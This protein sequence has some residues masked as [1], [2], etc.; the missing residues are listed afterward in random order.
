MEQRI[1]AEAASRQN[2]GRLTRQGSQIKLMQD[3]ALIA[4]EAKDLRRAIKATLGRV[5]EFAEWDLGHAFLPDGEDLSV[6]LPSGIWVNRDPDQGRFA[7][8]MERTGQA[9]LRIGEDLFGPL[10]ANGEPVVVADV[11]RCDRFMRREMAISCDLHGAF[12]LAIKANGKAIAVLEFYSTR[13]GW[14]PEDLQADLFDIGVHLGRVAERTLILERLERAA[15]EAVAANQAKTAFLANMSHELRTPLNA[16]I[17]FSELIKLEVFG[18]V[19]AA[20]YMDYVNDIH[21]SGGHLLNVINDV[22]DMSKIEAGQLEP[23][24]VDVD[25]ASIAQT[26]ISFSA[27]RA[28][29]AHV[30]LETSIPNELLA[31]FADD[32][33]MKQIILNLLSN[34]IKFTPK[35]GTVSLSISAD[36]ERGCVVE[37]RDNGMGMDPANLETVMRPFGQIDDDL[38]RQLE[39]TG[40]GL[41][42]VKSMTD[43][44]D[45]TLEIDTAL[46]RGTTVT[47]T[48]PARAGGG[49]RAP[50]A[51]FNF[52]AR[53][54]RPLK[55]FKL[56]PS[57][58]VWCLFGL[59]IF[60]VG[61]QSRH[62]AGMQEHHRLGGCEAPLADQIDQTSEG[63]AGIDRVQD[64]PLQP[65]R[66]AHGVAHAFCWQAIGRAGMAFND[67]HRIAVQCRP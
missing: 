16:I 66:Q 43:M 5:C 52:R 45:S 36:N 67:L 29:E 32:R 30:N 64:Q 56:D 18:P 8:F 40:L 19:G 44:H 55:P 35:Q 28:S 62:A 60:G 11:R 10:M 42:L 63:L 17:G 4:N 50:T 47:M 7:P 58:G 24:F 54:S 41:P 21:E 59:E 48:P 46:G 39:G 37:V 27:G 38:N 23:S 25:M 2:L 65:C 49:K 1:E 3:L 26:C 20:E 12:G 31:V 51:E 33:M 53:V 9:Q 57:R 61:K 6:L 22:L 13:K 15:S 34:A 14:P